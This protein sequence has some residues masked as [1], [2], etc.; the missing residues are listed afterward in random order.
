MIWNLN[1]NA[2]FYLKKYIERTDIF[3]FHVTFFA[4]FQIFKI[5]YS[6][7][8]LPILKLNIFIFSMFRKMHLHLIEWQDYWEERQCHLPLIG[9][10]SKWDES[11]TKQKTSLVNHHVQHSYFLKFYYLKQKKINQFFFGDLYSRKL[12]NVITIYVAVQ[13]QVE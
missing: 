4:S 2:K 10:L 8:Y 5:Q 3:M 9:L 6:I 7:L 1:K 13:E 11:T 12:L